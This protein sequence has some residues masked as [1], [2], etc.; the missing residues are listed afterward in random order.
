M[1]INVNFTA[2]WAAA[3][4]MGD[5]KATFSY[6]ANTYNA[7]ESEKTILRRDITLEDVDSHGGLLEVDGNQVLLYIEDHSFRVQDVITGNKEGNK[8]HIADCSKL[9]EMRKKH[10][11]DRYVVTNDVSGIFPVSGKESDSQLLVEGEAELHVCKLCLGFLNYRSYKSDR[12]NVFK[13]F[14]LDEFFSHYSTLFN[15]FPKTIADKR[16][17]YADDWETVSLNY[18]SKKNFCCEACHVDLSSYQ[19]LLHTHHVNGVKRDNV[20]S[21]LRALCIDCHRKE[22]LHEHMR[23]RS[24]EVHTIN[25]LRRS[26]S[27]LS[28]QDWDD[29]LAFADTSYHGLLDLYRNKNMAVPEI[30][31]DVT[32]EDDAVVATAELAWPKSK[33]AIIH[34]S[35][36]IPSLEKAGW[37]VKML[38][39]ALSEAHELKQR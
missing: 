16:G 35:A 8:Y 25:K 3:K 23:V 33:R 17:G 36:D 37:V 10:R 11:F 14:T 39:D 38:G 29:A 21:N 5:G 20:A 19:H 24:N 9:G 15:S 13:Q 6:K 18:R 2:L 34:Q 27:I 7:F 12:T 26:Q 28:S 32:D 31:Y 30:G 1:E 22:P 4:K